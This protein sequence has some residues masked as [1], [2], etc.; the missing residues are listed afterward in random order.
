MDKDLYVYELLKPLTQKETITVRKLRKLYR[1]FAKDFLSEISGIY[2]R[3]DQ[4]EE[5]T[6][7]DINQFGDLEKLREQIMALA[8]QLDK[9]GRKEIIRLLEDTYDYSYEW[10]AA[11]VNNAIDDKL[12]DSTPSLPQLVEETRKNAVYGLRLEESLERHRKL[13]VKEINEAIERGFIEGERY[14]GISKKVNAAFESSFSRSVTIARTEAHRVRE[15]A[16]H[17]SAVDAAAQGVVM[18]KVWNNVGDE[19]VRHSKRANHRSLQGQRRPINERFDLGNGVTAQAPG[20]SGS[21]SND[22]NCRCFVTY[23][24]VGLR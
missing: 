21:A 9:K 5:L 24:V 3:L 15:K 8:N 10:M 1:Q 19:R 4:G 14:V 6:Y 12:K 17:T 2:T 20:Q 18:E 23:E 22:I 13:I 11:T 16:T 7:A